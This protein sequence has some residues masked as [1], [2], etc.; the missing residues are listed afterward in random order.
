VIRICFW[1]ARPS[2]RHEVSAGPAHAE[3]KGS[4]PQPGGAV[5]SEN[6]F[7]REAAGAMDRPNGW[8]GH[9]GRTRMTPFGEAAQESRSWEWGQPADF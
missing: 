8:G 9:T 3:T 2:W 7:R 5:S 1:A 6:W 4:I